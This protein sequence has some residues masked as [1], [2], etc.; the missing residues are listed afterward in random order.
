[1]FAKVRLLSLFC[2]FRYKWIAIAHTYTNRERERERERDRERDRERERESK[3]TLRNRTA[4]HVLYIL[5]CNVYIIGCP[6]KLVS[7]ERSNFGN[8]TLFDNM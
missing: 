4:L 6:W 1:M 5:S 3:S 7:T 2:W 8:V